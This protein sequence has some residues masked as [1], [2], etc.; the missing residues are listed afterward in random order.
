MGRWSEFFNIIQ[1]ALKFYP[2]YTD[3]YYI[4]GSGII[5]SKNPE[6]F[7]K[8]PEIFNTCI[9]LGEADPQR[10]ET[11]SGVG[12]YRAHFNLGLYYE[13]TKQTSLAMEHYHLSSEQGFE[14]ARIRLLA[15]TNQ[16]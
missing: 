9:Y 8:L 2:D 7:A 11:V 6:W 13:L 4:Y 5:E 10:Y 1:H 15:L 12:S 14:A 3:L 16:N